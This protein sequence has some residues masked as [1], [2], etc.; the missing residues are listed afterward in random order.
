MRAFQLIDEIFRGKSK[1]RLSITLNTGLAREKQVTPLGDWNVWLILAGRGFSKTWTGAYDIVNY[2][3][4]HPNTISA[5]LAPTFG[6]L[7]REEFLK[8]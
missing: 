1:R 8:V 6:D 5:V 2:A 7:R 4:T 3:M